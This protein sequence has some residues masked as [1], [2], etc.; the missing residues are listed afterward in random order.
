MKK[1]LLFFLCF[2]PLLS[3]AQAPSIEGDTMLCPYT[4]GT[5]TITNDTEYDTYQWYYKYWFLN[6]DFVAIDGATQASFTYD[7]YTYDQSLFKVVVTL[8][9]QT[10]ESNTIQIDSYAWT[11]LIVSTQTSDD[12]TFN[13][14]NQA[15]YICDESTITSSTQSPYTVA[16]WYKND[17][18][19]EGA[20]DMSYTITEAG[21]YHVV[22]APEF[23]PS[24][25]STSLPIVVMD[26]P[27]CTT[28]DP[29]PVIAGDTML[30]PYTDGTATVTSDMEYDTYQWYYKFW[31]TDD[32]FVAIDGANEASF[33][34]DWYTY[35]QSLFKVV[36]TLD[37]ETYESNTIQIDSYNWAGL[38]VSTQTSDDVTFNP[39]NQAYYICDESTI[40][41][42]VQSPY[43]VVQWYKND[44][45]IEGATDINYTITEAGTYYVVAAP[46]FCPNSTSTSLPIV[47][48][49]NPEC[50]TAD[51]TPII[52]GDTMLCP[53]TDGTATVT[54]DM[55]YDTYQWYYKY[56]FTDDEF[57]AIDGATE[58]SFTYD[59]YT[60]DQALFK[61]VVAL[62]GETYESNTI[63]I[64]SYNW[65]GIS[66]SM[67]FSDDVVP[68][69][70]N[71]TWMI[72]DEST[73]TCELNSPYDSSIQWYKDGE[74]IEGANDVI[75]VITEPGSYYVEAGP[76][77]CSNSVSNT[78]E[79]PVVVTMNPDCSLG[80]ND[81]V[82]N[83]QVTLYPN[84]TSNIL[85]I[86]LPDNNT[87]T[88]YWII[89]V[90][91][92]TL[93]K[94]AFPNSN[95]ID[96]SSLSNGTYILKLTGGNSQTAHMFIRK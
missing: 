38:L 50:T 4:N 52:A 2:I 30:C 93:L 56:W 80:I 55:E 5:A 7:W 19:I 3:V 85:N 51:P 91:G 10:Y 36:V 96:V 16:Q 94:G 70:E 18:A 79:N 53:Y 84:P 89:D 90:T 73:I 27:E 33:T 13:P 32:E 26:N 87:V 43:T 23:C 64:D 82:V 44:V 22:A 35:D 81:P 21:T 9:G 68:N 48:M 12:V 86:T 66:F 25:T 11:G 39:D 95:S 34:Y 76:E 78:S 41:S 46:E 65:A 29:T 42:A 63:Q 17:V 58:A 45:A 20:T 92:K 40:T 28:V 88:D 57:V 8:D 14:D 71:F 77:Y 60:Y 67:T 6:D 62:D 49:D 75:Y 69:D 61:V 74:A 37:G 83:S 59:W 47:V 31:F 15:Y 1:L 72:C 24:S 54:N